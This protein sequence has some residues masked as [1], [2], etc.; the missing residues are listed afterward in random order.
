MATS[1]P[2]P[3][4]LSSRYGLWMRQCSRMVLDTHS[5]VWG[6]R[7]LHSVSE[8]HSSLALPNSGLVRA[9]IICATSRKSAESSTHRAA[10]PQMYPH[11]WSFRQLGIWSVHVAR[12]CRLRT[13]MRRWQLRCVWTSEG[14]PVLRSMSV[15]C[16][17]LAST[18]INEAGVF[19]LIMASKLPSAKKSQRWVLRVG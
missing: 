13:S 12:R 4:F 16:G 18:W 19:A 15:E 9:V 8:L 6:E 17:G 3:R 7:P 10:S 11:P 2:R 1:C 14:F 5:A